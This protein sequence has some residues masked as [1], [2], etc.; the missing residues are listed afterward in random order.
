MRLRVWRDMGAINKH[1]ACTM[2]DIVL[3]HERRCFVL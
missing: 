2:A 1:A 3:G